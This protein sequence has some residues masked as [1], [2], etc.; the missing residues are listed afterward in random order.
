[1]GIIIIPLLL[2][3]NKRHE[4]VL[5]SKYVKLM[6]IVINPELLLLVINIPSIKAKLEE[7]QVKVFVTS[8]LGG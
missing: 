8:I 5:P 2:D 7:S 1:M 6:T 4:S 3:L